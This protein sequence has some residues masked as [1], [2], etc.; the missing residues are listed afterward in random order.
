M[1]SP[2]HV[3]AASQ[4]RRGWALRPRCLGSNPDS[5]PRRLR[6][7]H[8]VAKCTQ[9]Q[10]PHLLRDLRTATHRVVRSERLTIRKA[11]DRPFALSRGAGGSSSRQGR[12]RGSR[13]RPRSHA[14]VT[15]TV[16]VQLQRRRGRRR[17]RP[18]ARS[19]KARSCAPPKAQAERAA[20]R[21][22]GPCRSPD[23]GSTDAAH[24]WG[25]CTLRLSSQG[26]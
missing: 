1:A 15:V 18:L 16:T 7:F 12:T 24:P 2:G 21:E 26:S 5:A 20:E 22:A 10:F 6:N 23:P 11:L 13:E 3:L 19:K 14:P 17:Q 8:E 9:P 4:E 25:V